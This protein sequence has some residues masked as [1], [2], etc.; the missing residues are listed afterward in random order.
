MDEDKVWHESIYDLA[1]EK[2]KI[3]NFHY[4]II[5]GE[6]INF[7][8]SLAVKLVKFYQILK[9]KKNS[10]FDE[11]SASLFSIISETVNIYY[12]LLLKN[13]LESKNYKII[14]DRKSRLL[15]NILRKKKPEF[16]KALSQ[17]IKGMERKKKAYFFLNF[18]K[19]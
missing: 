5:P 11:C 9:E 6:T 17:L 13:K 16:P 14:P 7:R 3:K 19:I 8:E 10:Y 18:L 15:N 4:P 12:T 1:I 2:D